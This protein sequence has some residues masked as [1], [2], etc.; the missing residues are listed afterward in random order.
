MAIPRDADFHICGPAAFTSAIVTDL[1][2]SG[3]ALDRL[4]NENFGPLDDARRRRGPVAAAA[5]AGASR[6]QRT[7][8]IL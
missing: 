3:I 1:A 6:G 4:D 8:C 5:S 2:G 7:A